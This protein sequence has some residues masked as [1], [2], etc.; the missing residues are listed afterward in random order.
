MALLH[1]ILFVPLVWIVKTA[2]YVAI[3]KI[4][5][6]RASLVACMVIAGAPLLVLVIP[7]PLPATILT[8]AGIGLA[9]YLTMRYT[10]VPLIPD[11]LLI[12]LAVEVVFRFAIWLI[13]E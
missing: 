6:I 4:R 9:V 13:K 2:A 7:I 1:Y 12:P 8:V 10:G 5:D 11:G 3:F